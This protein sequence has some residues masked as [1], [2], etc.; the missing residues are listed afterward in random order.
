MI[1]RDYK[2]AAHYYAMDDSR[3]QELSTF[4]IEKARLR[5]AWFLITMSAL[6][7]L[8]YGWS[9]QQKLASIRFC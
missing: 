6:S 7:I 4:P 2:I 1:D 5:S 3:S 9:I 8:G